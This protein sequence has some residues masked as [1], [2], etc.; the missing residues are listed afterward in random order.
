M[1]QLL[2]VFLVVAFICSGVNGQIITTPG[3]TPGVSAN[4]MYVNAGANLFAAKTAATAGTTI[5]VGPGNYNDTST[6]LLKNLVNWHFMNGA[7]VSNLVQRPGADAW[8][9]I[10]DDRLSGSVTCNITGD[11][12]FIYDRSDYDLGGVPLAT[13]G[14]FNLTNP[15]SQVS[16]KGKQVQLFSQDL[17]DDGSGFFAIRNCRK[18]WIDFDELI[19]PQAADDAVQNTGTGIYWER[20]DVWMRCRRLV[21]EGYGIWSNVLLTDMLGIT[22]DLYYEGDLIDTISKAA[23]YTS[24]SNATHRTWARVGQ[25]KTTSGGFGCVS[26]YDG[27]RIYIEAE[28]I[29]HNGIAIDLNASAATKGCEAWIT[30]QKVSS[31]IRWVNAT[32][33]ILYLNAQEYEDTSAVD[34]GFRFT[35]GFTTIGPGYAKVLAGHGLV[36]LGGTNRIIGLTIDTRNA[37]ST[38]SVTNYMPVTLGTSMSNLVLSGCTLLS[39]IATGNG[40]AYSV[41][42]TSGVSHVLINNGTTCNSNANLVNGLIAGLTTNQFQMR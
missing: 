33:G 24:M 13:Q 3:G 41:Y 2:K 30:C 12:V 16:I 38:T 4:V 7:I 22:N 9:G 15:A 21:T 5:V 20:G 23:I 10:F 25:L 18:C 1:T 17:A 28:K 11:G 32:K 26:V 29:S 31:D 37:G 6:N 14:F 39:P 35:G 40:G 42:S 34:Y 27:G 8:F 19:M 36:H